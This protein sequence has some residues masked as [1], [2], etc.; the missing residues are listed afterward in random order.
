MRD[1]NVQAE[2]S[3]DQVMEAILA[4]FLGDLVIQPKHRLVLMRMAATKNFEVGNFGIAARFIR[5]NFLGNFTDFSILLF[6]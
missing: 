5:V 3:D 4:R 2:E 1:D 6:L